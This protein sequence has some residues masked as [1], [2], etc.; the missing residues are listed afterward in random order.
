[1]ITDSSA[2]DLYSPLANEGQPAVVQC[3]ISRSLHPAELIIKL[4]AQSSFVIRVQ[5]LFNALI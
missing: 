5:G 1:M 2:A 4:D 3:P